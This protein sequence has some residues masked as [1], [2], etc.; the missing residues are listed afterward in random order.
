MI[1]KKIHDLCKILWPINRSITGN[2]V[3]KTLDILKKKCSEMKIYEV[4]SGTKVFDWTI[5]NEW[6]VKEAKIL[7][8][9]GK[10]ILDFYDN[11]LHLVG[12]STP[13][14]KKMSLKELNKHLFSLKEKPKAIPYVTSYYKKNWGFCLSHNNRKKLKSGKYKVLINSELKKGSLTYGEIFLPGKSKKEIFLSTYICHPSLANNEL[15]GPTVSIFIANWIKSLKDRKFSYRIIF[16]PETIGSI[17]Y[18]SKNLKKMKRN[19]YAGFNITCVGDERMYSYLPSRKGDTIADHTAKHIL[20]WTDKN[21]KKYTWLDRGS[22]ERQYCSPGIDLPVATIM[23]SKGGE[24]PEYHTSLDNLKNVVTP[25]GLNGSF[26]L[27]KKIIESFEFNCYPK[28]LYLCEPQ[29]SKRNLYPSTSNWSKKENYTYELRLMKDLI[30]FSD[31]KTSLL[32]I[33]EN[34]KVPI[35][36]FY[37]IIRKLE[38]NKIIKILFKI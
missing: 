25:K 24:Y 15:S 2:G 13:I 9:G 22:D 21:Y 23:R 1:G 16:I 32:N 28:N 11:N 37:S 6:N 38:K 20:K 12:Y 5:P 27:I 33:A 26:N 8:P 4:A 29:L 19:M 30:S 7:G 35:W 18:L 10:K 14:N 34:C 3:R 31:G 36:D 17:T